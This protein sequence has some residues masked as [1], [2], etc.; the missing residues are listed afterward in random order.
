MAL[1]IAS[2]TTPKTPDWSHIEVTP[3]ASILANVA[4]DLRKMADILDGS[5]FKTWDKERKEMAL[6]VLMG[7]QNRIKE[8]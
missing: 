2:D 4:W 3:Q 7:I 5:Q 6:L 8:L 1:E